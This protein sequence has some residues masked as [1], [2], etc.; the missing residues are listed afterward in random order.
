MKAKQALQRRILLSWFLL[1]LIIVPAVGIVVWLFVVKAPPGNA[2]L[3]VDTSELGPAMG[4]Q[5]PD[6]G[7]GATPP[8][9]LYSS[10]TEAVRA[11]QGPPLTT[12]I[13]AQL[14][15]AESTP[16][17]SQ[18]GVGPS[19]IVETIIVYVSG[20]VN[21]PGVYTLGVASRVADA[22]KMAGG[23]RPEADMERINLAARITDEEHISIPEKGAPTA[24][25]GSTPA[26]PTTRASATV[27]P[28]HVMININTATASELESLPGIGP[29]LAARIVEYRAAN[30]RFNT[31][32]E[33]TRVPGIKSALF[34][35]IRDHVTVG[36]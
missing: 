24:I 18:Q 27:T 16:L 15:G 1:A 13:P 22:V 31:I 7:Q 2:V 36:P 6:A 32:E 11:D 34:A 14:A 35:N 26:R 5:T 3:I 4:H 19:P 29:T 30:G 10:P 17:A 23:L 12:A 33:L 8:T 25:P 9:L 28:P 21:K 20:A